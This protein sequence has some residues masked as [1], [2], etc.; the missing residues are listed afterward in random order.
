[1]SLPVVAIIGINGALGTHAVNAFSS[2]LFKG[3]VA[4][5]IR[6]ISA[7]PAKAKSNIPKLNSSEYE[8]V[9]ANA[10]TGEGLDK[11]FEGVDVVINIA[12]ITFSHNKI[13]DA[14]AASKAKVYVPSEFGVPTN[15]PI[16]GYSPVL[17]FKSDAAK[18]A[19]SFKNF[20]TVSIYNSGFTEWILSTYDPIKKD[21]EG[22]I[23]TYEPD[24]R[25]PTTSLLNIGQVIA[26][27]A[28]KANTPEVIPEYLYIKGGDIARS[29]IATL[30]EKYLGSKLQ[31]VTKPAEEITVPAKKIVENGVTGFADFY[32]VLLAILT[33]GFGEYEANSQELVGD[34]F[35]FE[36]PDEVA[37]RIFSK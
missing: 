31:V 29:E 28:S 27:I 20:K 16:G 23:V 30:R 10:A 4:T 12:G 22:T 9:T 15:G 32:I 26:T 7:D 36:T 19:K 34:L 24:S 35:K 3:K 11:A 17:Q 6:I 2:P 14:V 13:I 1:M 5:P 37:K 8:F 18:Y 33:Q 21:P 25:W